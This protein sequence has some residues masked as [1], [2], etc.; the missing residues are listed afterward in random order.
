MFHLFDRVYLDFDFFHP[1][2]DAPEGPDFWGG[3]VSRGPR[4]DRFVVHL[5]ERSFYRTQLQYWR[6]I[7]PSANEPGLHFLHRTFIEDCRLRSFL[8]PDSEAIRGRERYRDLRP[9]SREEFAA[10][11]SSLPP[12]PPELAALSR[13]RVSFEYQLATLFLNP[14]TPLKSVVLEKVKHYTWGNWFAELNILK[15]DILNGIMDINRLLPPSAGID[16]RDPSCL[17]PQVLGNP[18]LSWVMDT[19]FRWPNCDHVIRAYDRTIFKE[20]YTRFYNLWEV[21]TEDMNELIDL[22]YTHQYETLL[23]RD[24]KRAFG[25]VY[26][27]GLFRSR[28]NQILVSWIYRCSRENRPEPLRVLSLE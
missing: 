13:E 23:M 20:L 6:T 8:S 1:R 15:G 11:W 25:S 17:L 7:L 21:D 3:L 5:D 28:I 10:E 14:A 12:V 18:Y 27:A 4:S 19:E 9:W 2:K 16:T 26:S 22:I 24:V